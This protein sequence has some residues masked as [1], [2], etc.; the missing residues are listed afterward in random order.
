MTQSP[1]MSILGHLRGKLGGFSPVRNGWPHK[2]QKW[3]Q[4]PLKLQARGLHLSLTC[5]L[6]LE[7][8]LGMRTSFSGYDL[9]SSN[10]HSQ[11]MVST[12]L[13]CVHNTKKNNK[14]RERQRTTTCHV[15][16]DLWQRDI[17][18][19]NFKTTRTGQ[20]DKLT[21]RL[22]SKRGKCMIEKLAVIDSHGTRW[23][24]RRR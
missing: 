16:N 4:T 20:N 23:S 19:Q 11:S 18:G 5:R 12:L 21:I 17:R 2:D 22:Y 1:K 15:I 3:W 7:P 6:S 9:W 13:L 14:I 8:P 24:R 10:H